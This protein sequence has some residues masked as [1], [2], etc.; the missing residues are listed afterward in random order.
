MRITFSKVLVR[1]GTGAVQGGAARCGT[2]TVVI[3]MM[4]E[5]GTNLTRTHTQTDGSGNDFYL[6]RA[7]VGCEGSENIF[8]LI[9]NPSTLLVPSNITF[10]GGL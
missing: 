3:M 4:A 1:G 6:K 10:Y 5:A 8:T 7:L 9:L 2:A